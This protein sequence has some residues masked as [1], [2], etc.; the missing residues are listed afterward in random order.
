M[1][2]TATLDRQFPYRYNIA[3]RQSPNFT[4]SIRDQADFQSRSVRD[5]ADAHLRHRGLIERDQVLVMGDEQQA[6]GIQTAEGE[7]LDRRQGGVLDAKNLEMRGKTEEIVPLENAEGRVANR[8]CA[9]CN[10][11]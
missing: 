8:D 7:P 6:Q 11:P 1:Q 3:E 2:V 4:Q 9:E 10:R 5:P